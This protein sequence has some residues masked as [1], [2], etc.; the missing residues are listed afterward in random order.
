MYA[1][2]ADPAGGIYLSCAELDSGRLVE[3]GP[4]TSAERGA[5]PDRM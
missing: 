2:K 1:A 4:R 3:T 5:K